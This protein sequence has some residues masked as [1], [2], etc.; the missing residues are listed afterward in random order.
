[1]TVH[2]IINYPSY[3]KEINNN[4]FK[5]IEN[6]ISK[7]EEN[8]NF[9]NIKPSE[10][11]INLEELL[12]NGVEKINEPQNILDEKINNFLIGK[13]DLHNVMV[14][15]E[16]ARFTIMFATKVRDKVIEAYETMM[17]MQI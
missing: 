8:I 14:A 10:L 17:R 1:M 4:N 11:D 2:N 16:N 9:N 5:K 12:K 6:E 13:E 7:I 15:A 3:L